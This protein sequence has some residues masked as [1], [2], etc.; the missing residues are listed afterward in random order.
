MNPVPAPTNHSQDKKKPPLRSFAKC[1]IKATFFVL[2]FGLA[3][4]LLW[5]WVGGS[6]FG[7][8]SLTYLQ[9][10][11]GAFLVGLLTFVFSCSVRRDHKSDSQGANCWFRRCRSAKRQGA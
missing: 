7:L 4:Q 10:V 1:I 5:N 6:V 9:A 2:I 3:L 8:P 11:G